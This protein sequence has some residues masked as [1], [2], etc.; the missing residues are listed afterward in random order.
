MTRETSHKLFGAISRF[1]CSMSHLLFDAIWC[2]HPITGIPKVTRDTK[3]FSSTVADPTKEKDP[4][5]IFN[6]LLAICLSILCRAE[7]TGVSAPSDRRRWRQSI[8]QCI[9]F[10]AVLFAID[11]YLILKSTGW[12]CLETCTN[13]ASL[14]NSTSAW[15]NFT[16]TASST[17]EY[18]T[19]FCFSLTLLRKLLIVHDWWNGLNC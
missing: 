19:F 13:S 2:N 17:S 8:M 9:I 12:H 7:V 1:S 3:V 14:P 6:A 11:V 5:S 10:L 16:C 4:L 15:S 18:T